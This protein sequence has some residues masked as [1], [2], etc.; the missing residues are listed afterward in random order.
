MK[1]NAKV[2]IITPVYNAERFLP[3]AIESVLAQ[4]YQNWEL[5]L[6]VDNKSRD[7]SSQIAEEAASADSRIRVIKNQTCNSASSNRNQ[8]LKVARGEYI[9]FL[10]ADDLWQP[11]KLSYQIAFMH[12]N[13]FQFTFHPFERIDEN[14]DRIGIVN[15][16][17][18]VSYQ[19]ILSN[20]YIA[21]CLT[22]IL[23]KDIIKDIFFK[24][25]PQEDM[26]FFLDILRAGVIGH[27]IPKIL[28]SYRVTRG[29][30]S[31][32]KL[33]SISDRWKLL[34]KR[35]NIPFLKAI[36][37]MLRYFYY[38]LKVRFNRWHFTHRPQQDT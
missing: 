30:R 10:D 15:H 6:V 2:S 18:E 20:S 3:Q 32:N 14:G 19:D 37:L 11:D 31:G 5:L 35:E 33:N 25:G 9:A 36:V 27:S 17:S 28:G 12:K 26:S 34:R 24:E 29:S 7:N 38:S 4:S 16:Y 8:A 13:N 1:E 23:S 21:G 22:V